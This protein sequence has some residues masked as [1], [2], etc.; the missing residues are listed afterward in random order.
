M[1]KDD[2]KMIMQSIAPTQSLIAEV[3]AQAERIENTRRKL[4]RRYR[5]P[6]VIAAV[7]VS[8]SVLA[9]TPALA[10]RYEPTYNIM[11]A[12]SPKLAQYFKLVQLSCESNGIE[13]TVLSSYVHDDTA[14]IYVAMRDLE[15]DRIDETVDFFDSERINI[16]F[17]SSGNCQREGY[18]EETRTATFKVTVR[19]M[20]G[21]KI[22]NDKITFSVGQ[23][24]SHKHYD[25]N[26]RIPYNFKNTH[27]AVATQ[28]VYVSGRAVS[29]IELFGTN[30]DFPDYFKAIVPGEP[31][32]N[33]P[34]NGIDLTG[35]AYIDGELH[36]QTAVTDNLKNDNHCSIYLRD[37]NGNVVYPIDSVSFNDSD[38][39]VV[40]GRVDY[41]ENVFDVPKSEIGSYTLWGDF[42]TCDTLTKG[43]WSVTYRIENQA[44]TTPKAE[45][46]GLWEV[47]GSLDT[48]KEACETILNAVDYYDTANGKIRTN[49]LDGDDKTIEY[50]VDMTDINSTKTYEHTYSDK[51]NFDEEVYALNGEVD[52]DGEKFTLDHVETY[53]NVNKTR[54]RTITETTSKADS[55]R[56]S[57]VYKKIFKSNGIKK[58]EYRLNPT[59]AHYAS[60]VSIFPQELGF[61]LLSDFN[62]WEL[63]SIKVH[64]NRLCR[65]ITGIVP[66]DC[67][68][69]ENAYSYSLLVDWSSGIILES[70]LYDE[71]GKKVG[72]MDTV[73]IS[74]D[75][76]IKVKMPDTEKYKGYKYDR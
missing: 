22:T 45:E 47:R 21:E 36:V 38:G 34:V 48:K 30:A 56:S 5:I 42:V 75:E 72:Y 64:F 60:T 25:E 73:Q 13:M 65:R 51:N 61:Q 16:P 41:D 67:S 19:T 17:D 70:K 68:M 63:G 59:D 18:D 37:E 33:F 46:S 71:N 74:I 26:V 69:A 58:Y 27:D 52:A 8:V 6:A 10:A 55:K 35:V 2:Y 49:L 4:S 23:F 15:G 39:I 44:G 57:D 40:D 54:N 43:N 24:L 12:I 32:E 20:N 9:A 7:L 11:Y 53:D 29:D 3:T 14:E 31:Y 1:F 62:K 66:E 50:Q 76:D 28:E